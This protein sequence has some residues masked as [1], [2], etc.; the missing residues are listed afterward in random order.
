LQ[1]LQ[2]HSNAH[3]LGRAHLESVHLAI[4]HAQD[5][6]LERLQHDGTVAGVILLLAV[7]Q[8]EGLDPTE[9]LVFAFY[10]GV[11]GGEV[12]RECETGE[13]VCDDVGV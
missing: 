12:G 7:F 6:E 11:G 1:L 8:T 2:A 13:I 10:L 9:E 5:G 3:S 4:E